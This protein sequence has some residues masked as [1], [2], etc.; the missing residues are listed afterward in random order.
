MA[1]LFDTKLQSIY[2]N[3]SRKIV[4]LMVILKSVYIIYEILYLLRYISYI[5]LQ[6]NGTL[7]KFA[8]GLSK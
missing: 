7:Q 8:S 2:K 4:I 3:Y 6:F 1:V 5:N